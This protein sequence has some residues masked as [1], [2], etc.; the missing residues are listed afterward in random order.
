VIQFIDYLLTFVLN[1]PK[2]SGGGDSSNTRS[3]RSSGNN[4]KSVEYDVR[5]ACMLTAFDSAVL[6]MLM[7]PAVVVRFLVSACLRISDGNAHREAVTLL[8]STIG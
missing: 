8:R 4:L 3:S 7:P 1:S 5:S 6:L 2:V